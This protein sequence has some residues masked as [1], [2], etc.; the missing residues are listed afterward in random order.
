MAITQRAG[1]GVDGLL[2]QVFGFL[3][4]RTD[5]YYEAEPGD[6]MGFPPTIAEQKV[7]GIFKNYQKSHQQRFPPKE[8]T[9]ERWKEFTKKQQEAVEAEK[10]AKEEKAQKAKEAKESGATV[11]EIKETA[12][13]SDS[14]AAAVAAQSKAATVEPV[15]VKPKVEPKPVSKAVEEMQK[16]STYNGA[17][18]KDYSWA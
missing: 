14:K 17:E 3:L 5:F 1:E 18:L 8:G 7:L 11:E 6:K 13:P 4:R 10:K 2:N 12:E 15:V 16:M 9:M